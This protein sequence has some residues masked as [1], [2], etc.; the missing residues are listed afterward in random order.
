MNNWLDMTHLGRACLGIADCRANLYI[1][2]F[3]ITCAIFAL[4][5]DFGSGCLHVSGSVGQPYSRQNMETEN[6]HAS[7]DV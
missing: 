3:T 6:D 4:Y 1:V 5:V 2:F 7:P